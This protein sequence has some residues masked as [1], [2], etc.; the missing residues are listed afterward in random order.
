MH[1]SDAKQVIR[2]TSALDAGS[3]FANNYGMLH[4]G[5]PF[6]GFKM[7]GIGREL[8][9]AG[10]EAYCQTKAVHHNLTQEMEWPI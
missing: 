5:V 8:G 9:T 7:S 1:T 6:G 2:V 10:L 3:V 4:T